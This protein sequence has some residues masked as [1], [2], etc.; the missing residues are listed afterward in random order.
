MCIIRIVPVCTHFEVT[1]LEWGGKWGRRGPH[2]TGQ[3]AASHPTGAV[4]DGLLLLLPALLLLC[5]TGV[6]PLL[7]PAAATAARAAPEWGSSQDTA[8]SGAT[9]AAS[10]GGSGQ[11]PVRWRSRL[12]GRLGG[13]RHQKQQQQHE[14]ME[15]QQK[16]QQR[17]EA[18]T[19]AAAELLALSQAHGAATAANSAELHLSQQG[20]FLPPDSVLRLSEFI[21]PQ[22]TDTLEL[23]SWLLS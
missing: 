12:L 16:L 3:C 10:G 7:L 8:A 9:G 22:D 15:Q 2:P 18:S 14:R 19:A 1:G 17:Q 5:R 11:K 20:N 13:G 23:Y 21:M 6:S 4:A